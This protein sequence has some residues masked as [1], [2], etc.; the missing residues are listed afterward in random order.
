M[1]Q[2]IFLELFFYYLILYITDSWRI[3]YD[4]FVFR[5]VVPMGVLAFFQAFVCNLIIQISGQV[6]Y[7]KMVFQ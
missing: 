1:I 7:Y 3:I 2:H 4:R 6:S 5:I